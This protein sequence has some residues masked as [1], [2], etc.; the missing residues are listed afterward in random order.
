MATGEE[1]WISSLS[2]RTL[3][4][5][6]MAMVAA[7]ALRT[8]AT[9]AGEPLLLRC[10]LETAPTHTR[11]VVIRDYL[12]RIESAAGGRI[13]TQLFESGQLFP[14]LQVGKALLQ[15]QIEMAVPGTL[16]PDRHRARCGFL[17]TARSLWTLDRVGAPCRRWQA[18]AAARETD[19]AATER[20]RDRPV[21]RSWIFQ[22]VQHEQAAEFL[23]R[24][25]GPENPQQRRGGS[26]VADAIH[27]R[28]PQYHALAE[29]A[30]WPLARHV[31][32]ADHDI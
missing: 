17:S 30:A 20:A 7:P 15:G 6:A 28:D 11:N 26:S 24:S 5:S 1:T 21:A 3:V 4:A 18:R 31:R 14:D 9:A 2:R 25:Q 12:G 8:G 29:R 19:R 32:R 13:K 23:C 10:S 22:L 27:G 16:V